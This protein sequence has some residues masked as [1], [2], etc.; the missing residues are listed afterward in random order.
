MAATV[1][2]LR[3]ITVSSASTDKLNQ[4]DSGEEVSANRWLD[5]A[6]RERERERERGEKSITQLWFGWR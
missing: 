2:Q 3:S 4:H 5:I 6:E 1:A